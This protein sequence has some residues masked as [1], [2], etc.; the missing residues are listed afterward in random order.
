MKYDT[1]EDARVAA[2]RLCTQIG[3]PVCIFE[4]TSWPLQGFYL[5]RYSMAHTI[6]TMTLVETVGLIDRKRDRN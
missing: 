4:A 1:H 3:E 2:N 5:M 6:V